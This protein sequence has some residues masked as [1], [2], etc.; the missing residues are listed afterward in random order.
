MGGTL[1][2][3]MLLAIA[4]LSISSSISLKSTASLDCFYLF[5][6]FIPSIMSWIMKFASFA[7]SPKLLNWKYYSLLPH[8]LEAVIERQT[9][10]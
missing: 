3:I 6:A 8:A 1:S 4:R 7:S 10:L 9:P 5:F 2:S